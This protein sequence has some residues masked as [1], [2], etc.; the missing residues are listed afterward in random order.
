MDVVDFKRKAKS[1][2]HSVK[3]KFKK[4]KEYNLATIPD[5][6]LVLENEHQSED[7]Y[8]YHVHEFTGDRMSWGKLQIIE[9]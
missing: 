6:S 9:A 5:L 8:V 1:K 4:I 2:Y 7:I 3:V